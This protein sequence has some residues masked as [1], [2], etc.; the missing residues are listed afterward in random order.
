MVEIEFPKHF[1][2]INDEGVGGGGCVLARAV[3]GPFLVLFNWFL[4]F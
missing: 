3:V 2:I 4:S 1:I